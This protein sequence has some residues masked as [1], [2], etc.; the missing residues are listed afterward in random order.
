MKMNKPILEEDLAKLC[1]ARDTLCSFC[2][3]DAC[4]KC[5]VTELINEAFNERDDK[6]EE[7]D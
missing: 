4:E 6:N 7:N 1:D 2:E 3:N 5:I